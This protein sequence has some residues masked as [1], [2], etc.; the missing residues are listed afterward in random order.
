MVALNRAVAVGMRDGPSAGLV[1][2]EDLLSKGVLSDYH[3]AH[4]IRAD[5]HRRLGNTSEARL[6]YEKAL[7]WARQG[8]ER[9]FLHRRLKSLSE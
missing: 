3:L 1:M 6:S 4:A 7:Y 8:P 5:L 2:V 9:R